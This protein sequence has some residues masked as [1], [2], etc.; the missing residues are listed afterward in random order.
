MYLWYEI[1]AMGEIPEVNGNISRMGK[2]TA[3][4][5]LPW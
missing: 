5:Y 2:A 3:L 4:P 1:G